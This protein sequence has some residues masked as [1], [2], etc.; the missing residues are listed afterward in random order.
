MFEGCV[1]KGL[2]APNAY[3]LWILCLNFMFEL[4]CEIKIEG[5][6]LEFACEAV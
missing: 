6:C 3:G 1:Q 4:W 5:L 2:A